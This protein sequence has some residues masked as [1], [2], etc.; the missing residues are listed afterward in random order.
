MDLKG[1]AKLTSGK[2]AGLG[3]NEECVLIFIPLRVL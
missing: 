1:E 3:E 2:A